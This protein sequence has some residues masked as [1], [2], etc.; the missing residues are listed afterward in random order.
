MKQNVAVK[1]LA[2]AV[3]AAAFLAGAMWLIHNEG[4]RTRDSIRDAGKDAASEIRKGIVEGA[5]QAVDRAVDKAVEAPRKIIRDVTKEVVDEAG[6]T[7][8]DVASETHQ[9][10]HEVADDVKDILKAKPQ[11]E[12]PPVAKPQAPTS[13]P[14]AQSDPSPGPAPVVKPQAQQPPV[15]KPQASTSVPPS[16]SD[17]SPGPPP[18]AKPQ[19]A[20]Q[21]P[22]ESSDPIGQL[23]DLGHKVTQ[24]GDEIG[25]EALGLTWDEEQQVG[26]E[27]HRMVCRD[28]KVSRPPK[29]ISRLERLAKPIIA[30]RT[31][32]ELTFKFYVIDS[33][34]VNAFALVG[35][36]IYVNSGIL[37][38]TKSDTE[39]QFV[40]AHEIGHQELRHVAKRMTYAVRASQVGGEQA[41]ALTQMAYM[42]IAI[43]Y[44]KKQELEAD[45]WGY[46][47]MRG[48][49][50]SREESLAGMKTLLA[51]SQ[52][53]Q[54]EPEQPEA[55]DA[56]QK[57]ARQ[58]ENHFKS[59]PP[60]A[61]RLKRLE[62]I[63]D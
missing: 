47:A 19:A 15:V 40:L 25:Q 63:K 58:L 35:G 54:A 56:A 10:V 6:P 26:A 37:D 43:G 53:H 18:V 2:V 52:Q 5:D 55:R 20:E 61:E 28:C 39:L 12:Q 22:A 50:H 21:K 48:A 8:K 13:V 30:Q 3:G 49:G 46:R 31:R 45:A 62:A 16:Q 7:V 41:G 34:V 36:Y 4:Q 57:V 9:A 38:V 59:H 11:A 14:P 24:M 44:S 29:V 60:T 1:Y 42:A 23:F 27:A 32:K 33:D 17:P 51:Y